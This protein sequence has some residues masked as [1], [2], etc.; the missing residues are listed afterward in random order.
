MC[1]QYAILAKYRAV[2]LRISI[3]VVCHGENSSMLKNVSQ[4]PDAR[5]VLWKM[6]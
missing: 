5:S 1:D 3:D 4:M 2:M 6:K